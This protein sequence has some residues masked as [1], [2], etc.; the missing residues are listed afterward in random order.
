MA[1][2]KFNVIKAAPGAKRA[3]P[4]KKMKAGDPSPTTFN[5]VDDG[6]G[7]AF[8]VEGVDAAGSP[9]D[10][11]AVASITSITSDNPAAATADPPSGVKGVLHGVPPAGGK[12]NIS[13]VVTWND[14]AAGIGPF[15]GTA[16]A[17]VTAGPT[18]GVVVVLG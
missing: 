4:T 18:T 17:T 13:V 1:N 10:I 7:G 9:T 5:L 16:V 2:A 3:V 11:S 6:T 14:P 15:T 12:A 8:H